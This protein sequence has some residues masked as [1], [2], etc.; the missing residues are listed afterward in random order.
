MVIIFPFL[1]EI[2]D[3]ISIPTNISAFNNDEPLHI[4]STDSYNVFS[5]QNYIV[6]RNNELYPQDVGETEVLLKKS[7][8]PIKKKKFNIFVDKKKVTGGTYSVCN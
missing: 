6:T 3:Y 1:T 2:K 8:I 4:S 5:D 7:N